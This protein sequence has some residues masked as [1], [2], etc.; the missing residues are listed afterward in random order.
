MF[1][2]GYDLWRRVQKDTRIMW[3]SWARVEMDSK[4]IRI[5]KNY[6]IDQYA[7]KWGNLKIEIENQ[8]GWNR[9]TH[10]NQVMLGVK[11]HRR[12]VLKGW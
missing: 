5:T 4:G 6:I 9:F 11:E 12:R 7:S 8:K 3:F 10:E 1:I 2:R